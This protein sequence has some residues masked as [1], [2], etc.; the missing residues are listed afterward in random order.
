MCMMAK[1]EGRMTIAEKMTEM[2]A[3]L[4]S[5]GKTM[6]D[7]SRESGVNYATLWRWQAGKDAK[8][9]TW[10]KVQDAFATLVGAV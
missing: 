4:R 1:S 3:A 7:L 6:A 10:T 9:E 2:D 5:A 8:M